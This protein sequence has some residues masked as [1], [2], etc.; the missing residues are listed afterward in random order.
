MTRY[1]YPLL[2]LALL[3]I[4][5]V[6]SEAAYKL[7]PVSHGQFSDLT[8]AG[9]VNTDATLA[10]PVLFNSNDFTPRGIGHDTT[11]VTVTISQANPGLVSYTATAAFPALANGDAVIF[12]TDGTLPTGLTKDT[13]VY[14]VVNHSAG[15]FNVATKPGGT[16]IQTTSAG[17]G[18]HTAKSTHRFY[19]NSTGEWLVTISVLASSTTAGDQIEYWEVL[20]GTP[21]PNSN[22][23]VDIARNAA[24][25][26]AS[27]GFIIPITTA[28][29]KLE[30]Y[31]RCSNVRA[32]LA[33]QAIGSNPTR[34]AAP[35][36]IMTI[37]K[38]S[39]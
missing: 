12:S 18:T 13:V 5:A 34:P 10:I 21:V 23:I 20:D 39:K 11:G 27:V 17:S 33:Y 37:N 3:I 14:Y 29:Q 28:G 4:V 32:T 26:V 31:W 2:T 1:K 15:T 16:G 25:S 19:L 9:Q 30:V 24:V 6:L 8:T 22:T 35:S 7:P 36:V 38:I